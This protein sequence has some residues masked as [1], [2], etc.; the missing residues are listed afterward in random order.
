MKVEPVKTRILYPPQDDLL[1]ALRD[2]TLEPQDGNVVVVSSKV[3]AIHEGRCK[4]ASEVKKDALVRAEADVYVKEADTRWRICLKHSALLPSAGIDETNANGYF[5]LLPERPQASAVALRKFLQETY[6]VQDIGVIIADSHS[7]PLRYGT[8]GIAL[9]WAGIEPIAHF[10]GKPDIFSR[11]AEYT[12]INVADSLAVA[13][14]F[15]TG[16][17]AEQTPVAVVQD[18]PYATFTDRDT[19]AELMIPP[20]EDIYWPLI[21][22]LYEHNNR[23]S[24]TSTA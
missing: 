20:R 5:V 17:L 14:V 13:G 22:H 10:S 19:S 3:I 7:M 9:G 12:R 6:D 8:I 24:D 23:K 11:P 21:K 15:A 1:Q 2:S 16:E 4:Q 18:A